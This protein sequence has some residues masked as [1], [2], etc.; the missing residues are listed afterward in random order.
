[1]DYV[2]F[3]AA[4]ATTLGLAVKS[5]PAQGPDRQ[6]NARHYEIIGLTPDLE[7]RLAA[8][9]LSSEGRHVV[10]I[11]DR[12]LPKLGPNSAPAPR[13]PRKSDERV[14]HEARPAARRSHVGTLTM[15]TPMKGPI[16]SLP[17]GL[18]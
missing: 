2:V 4:L 14:G 6:L 9:I 15:G 11:R 18:R 10:R 1:M 5:V 8:S 13:A 12:D 7:M 3:P 17:F 16:R